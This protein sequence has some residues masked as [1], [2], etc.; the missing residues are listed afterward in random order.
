MGDIRYGTDERPIRN[1][2]WRQVVCSCLIVPV[3]LCFWNYCSAKAAHRAVAVCS[4]KRFTSLLGMATEKASLGDL[5]PHSWPAV[6][7]LRLD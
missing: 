6:G 5:F 4:Q 3:N 2:G 1:S 7:A